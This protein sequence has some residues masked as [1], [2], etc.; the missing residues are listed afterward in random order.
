MLGR[1]LLWELCLYRTALFYCKACHALACLQHTHKF[2]RVSYCRKLL[3]V[4][5]C[6]EHSPS[7]DRFLSKRTIQVVSKEQKGESLQCWILDFLLS[8]LHLKASVFYCALEFLLHNAHRSKL[9][10]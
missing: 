5:S 9:H 3:R 7:P 4:P 2:L 8:T 10:K 6:L 1:E